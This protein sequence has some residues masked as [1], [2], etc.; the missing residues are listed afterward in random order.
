MKTSP[1]SFIQSDWTMAN[2]RLCEFYGLPEPDKGGFQKVSPATRAQS[3]GPHHRCRTWTHFG[4]YPSPP[5]SSSMV[6]KHF[7]E[8]TLLLRPT[9]TDRTQSPDSPK[10]TIRQKLK[11]TPRIQIVRPVTKT[12]IHRAWPLINLMQSGNGVPMRLWPREKVPT[13]QST[14]AEKCLTVAL[15]QRP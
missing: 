14:R 12:L 7:L 3:G 15:C 2:P 8:N 1:D 5:G 13:H 6:R 11:L 4:W 9:S 10:A